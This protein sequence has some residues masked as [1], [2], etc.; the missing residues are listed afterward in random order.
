MCAAGDSALTRAIYMGRTATVRFLLERGA[1]PSRTARRYLAVQMNVALAAVGKMALP[2][3]GTTENYPP[4]D[5]AARQRAMRVLLSKAIKDRKR[6][7][8]PIVAV[9]PNR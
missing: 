2:Q 7:R 8:K 4:D 6:G 1:D 3:L 5:V 9:Q